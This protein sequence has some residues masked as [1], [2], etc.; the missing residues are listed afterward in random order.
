MRNAKKCGLWAWRSKRIYLCT[1]SSRNI[2]L[3][4][5]MGVFKMRNFRRPHSGYPKPLFLAD[6]VPRYARLRRHARK[7]HFLASCSANTLILGMQKRYGGQMWCRDMRAWSA[8]PKAQF[9]RYCGVQTC[10]YYV[11][12][13][14]FAGRFGAEVCAL[15]A[16]RQVPHS[17]SHCAVQTSP[18][19]ICPG[20]SGVPVIA[21]FPPPNS[22]RTHPLD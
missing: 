18:L 14:T 8:T 7:P 9:F 16:P 19:R 5:S 17:F 4:P 12:K 6:L 13:N 20:F 2:F 10:L 15:G 11:S 3:L 1:K 22:P 21:P